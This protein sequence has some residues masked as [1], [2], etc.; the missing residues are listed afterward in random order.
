MSKTWAASFPASRI[1]SI[2]S[3]VFIIVFQIPCTRELL[4]YHVLWYKAAAKVAIK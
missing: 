1:F 3:A 4:Q 2:S